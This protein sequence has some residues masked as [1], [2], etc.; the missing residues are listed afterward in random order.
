M[1]VFQ[2]SGTA[3][4]IDMLQRCVNS[5]AAAAAVFLSIVTKMTSRPVALVVS[6]VIISSSEHRRSVYY[7]YP[8]GGWKHI[9]LS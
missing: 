1:Q 5:G 2:C 6:K 9:S 3:I 8:N 7:T 4:T